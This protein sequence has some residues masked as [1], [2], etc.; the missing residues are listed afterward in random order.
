M[1]ITIEAANFKIVLRDDE[2]PRGG[3][4]LS[5]LMRDPVWKG[6]I[7]RLVDD[8]D[9]ARVFDAAGKEPPLKLGKGPMREIP[10]DKDE[11]L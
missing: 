4:S 3:L 2:I 11:A 8:I 1:K 6:F 9:R 10:M 5:T 7:R